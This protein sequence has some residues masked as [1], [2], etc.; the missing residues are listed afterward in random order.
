MTLLEPLPRKGGVPYDAAAVLDEEARLRASGSHLRAR[1]MARTI[2]V[3]EV[4]LVEAHRLQGTAVALRRPGGVAGYGGL[5]N[6]LT[7]VGEI[8]ALTRNEACVSERHGVY[9]KPSFHGAMGQVLGEIDLRLFLRHWAYGYA[10]TE[11]TKSGERLSLQFFDG[12]GDAVHKIYATDGTDRELFDALITRHADPEALPALYAPPLPEPEELADEEI[13]AEGLRYNWRKLNHSHEFSG[14]LRRFR[15]T[16]LQAM[17]L[18]GPEFTRRVRP[19]AA[20]HLL[21]EAAS[22]GVPLMIFVGNRGCMQIYSGVVNRVAR[23][24]GWMNVLDPRFNLH[25]R[26]DLI[27]EAWVVRKPSAHGEVHALELFDA[28]GFCFAQ[29]LGERKP[30]TTERGD[31]RALVTALEWT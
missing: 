2:G 27:D 21:V 15:A 17:R 7:E 25:L 19:S 11:Q 5:L 22:R 14:L 12:A 9:A 23:V 10:V 20:E 30:G 31:W 6:A 16:R 1:D 24:N 3:P 18:G 29:F 13:D 28:D 4:A 8:M 26:A